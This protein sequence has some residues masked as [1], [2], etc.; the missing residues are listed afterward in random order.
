MNPI[1][2]ILSLESRIS[3]MRSSIG[4]YSGTFDS[5][6]IDF[7]FWADAH[8]R[9]CSPSTS[10]SHSNGSSWATTVDTA[11]RHTIAVTPMNLM[12]SPPS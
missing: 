1:P 5:R 6:S 11:S 8:A 3:V 7:S 12:S 9:A 10:S 4:S 2:G